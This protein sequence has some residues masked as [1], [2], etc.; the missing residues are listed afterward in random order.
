MSETHD[1]SSST[2]TVME[3]LVSLS[4]A[5]ILFRTFAVEGYMISTGSMAPTLLGYHK[6][7]TCPACRYEFP[8]G[9]A[10]DESVDDS[11]K[12]ADSPQWAMCPNCG[13]GGIDVR[14][15]PRNEGDQLL[16]QK[17]SYSFIPPK[18]WEVV[19]FRNPDHPTD[20]YV[21]RVAGL[22]GESVQ[23]RHGDLYIN[24]RLHHKHIKAQRAVRILVYDD[25][26]SPQN[27]KFWKPRWIPVSDLKSGQKSAS[28]GDSQDAPTWIGKDSVYVIDDTSEST[29]TRPIPGDADNSKPKQLAETSDADMKWLT[30]R[31]WIRSGGDHRSHV[32]M[33]S[34]PDAIAL[35]ESFSDRLS[36][37]AEGKHLICIG[38]MPS[39]VAKRVM[40][41][42]NDLSFRKTIYDL[43]LQSHIAPVTD[44]YGYN[45][46]LPWHN[47]LDVHDLMCEFQLAFHR[48]EGEF[49]VQMRVADQTMRG[50]FD[51]ESRQVQL[52][53]NSDPR[54]VRTA[55]FD[56][57]WLNEPARVEMSLFDRQVILAVNGEPVFTSYPFQIGQEESASDRH[58]IQIGARGLKVQVSEL[59]VYRDVYYTNGKGRH[60]VNEPCPLGDGEYFMLGDNSPVSLDSRSW[61]NAAVSRE[62]L[63]GK[64][65]FVHLPSKPG[66]FRWGNH[67]INFRVP[68]F[69]RIRYVR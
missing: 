47:P 7:V 62:Q 26:C 17:D 33:N 65:L 5:V 22:P 39:D 40:L 35:P 55:E 66:K 10:F 46:D 30:Y 11:G 38:A 34:W 45:R 15:Q 13:Q 50:V 58:P 25:R 4:L 27:D 57:L 41:A 49:V 69:S 54:P 36:Y 28:K 8:F 61:V 32:P 19:V 20:V 67:E 60:G 68:D 29:T 9:V 31:H 2:R 48:G 6:R 14:T 16:V 21:K 18:R 63:L 56:E 44:E 51:V 24:G 53:V 52:Y 1:R 23:V 37:H 3:S 12:I 43:Y 42:S 64:P 59:K